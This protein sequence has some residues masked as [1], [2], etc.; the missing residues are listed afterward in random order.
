MFDPMSS[1]YT[2]NEQTDQNSTQE[3]SF[4]E[5]EENTYVADS[6][7]LSSE[8]APDQKIKDSHT[9]DCSHVASILEI[10]RYLTGL[11]FPADKQALINCAQ[12]NGASP[13]VLEMIERFP[14]EEE[15]RKMSEIERTYSPVLLRP[16]F[17]MK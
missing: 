2:E 4:S 8:D 12:S 14:D 17:N 3:P 16:I 6:S 9:H 10:E 11:K 13:E 5:L 7:D 15:Y 1:V